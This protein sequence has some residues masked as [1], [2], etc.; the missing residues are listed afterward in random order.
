MKKIYAGPKLAAVIFEPTPI[1][2]G[3][4]D[5]TELSLVIDALGE[6]AATIQRL[7]TEREYPTAGE[8]LVRAEHLERMI[9]ELTAPAP[10]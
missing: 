8:M 4:E 3:G 1:E 7:L 5:V 10:Q 9:A 2:G 6:E